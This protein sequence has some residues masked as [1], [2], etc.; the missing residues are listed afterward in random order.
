MTGII[1]FPRPMLAPHSVRVVAKPLKHFRYD[2][3]DADGLIVAQTFCFE[4]AVAAAKAVSTSVTV[5]G[6]PEAFDLEATS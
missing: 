4:T 5:S 2:V 6:P 1:Q 3:I